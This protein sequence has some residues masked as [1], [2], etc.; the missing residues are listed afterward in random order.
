MSLFIVGPPSE[1]ST[2]M[3]LTLAVST[4]I[5]T[6]DCIVYFGGSSNDASMLPWSI[7]PTTS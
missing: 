1:N 2:Q 5:L 7:G 6:L 4:Q 3:N